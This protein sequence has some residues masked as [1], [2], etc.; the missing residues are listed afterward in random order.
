M[1]T[2]PSGSETISALVSNATCGNSAYQNDQ[3]GG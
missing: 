2:R 3:F 1:R